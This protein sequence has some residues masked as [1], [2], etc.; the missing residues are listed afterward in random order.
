MKKLL[1]FYAFIG[2][3]WSVSGQEVEFCTSLTTSTEPRFQNA[4]G[5][6]FQYQK[7]I[8]PWLKTGM[9]VQYI[10]ND[11]RFIALPYEAPEPG[12]NDTEKITS[13][14]KR[15]SF[16]LN[17]QGLI[18]DNKYVSWSLG[19][20]VSFNIFWGKDVIDDHNL[21]NNEWY[22]D[23]QNITPNYIFGLGLI[24]KFEVK[25]III[26]KLSVVFTVRPEL[27]GNFIFPKGDFDTYP[28]M[29]IMG[30]TEFQIG[31]KYRFKL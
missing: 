23:T 28:F 13:F 3:V 15:A 21:S 18:L 16:R 7:Y 6:G 8:L 17:I 5:I 1:I 10:F 4:I 27:V 25:H 20:E 9:G 11:N 24:S 31:L 12:V 14:P 19:P 2:V 22:Q 26:P 29:G 30:F